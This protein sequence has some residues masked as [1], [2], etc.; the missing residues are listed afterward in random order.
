MTPSITRRRFLHASAAGAAMLS[1]GSCATAAS[2]TASSSPRPNG[3]TW[4]RGDFADRFDPWIEIDRSAYRNNV[5]E[6]S[7][8]AG[9][10]PILAVVK[11]NAYGLG[12]EA[13]GPLV[14]EMPEVG[15]IACVRV[16][17][18]LAMRDVGVTKPI[19]VMAEA[20]EDEMV[21]LVRHR[22]L[23]S[24]WL[25]DAPERIARVAARVGHPVP[26]QL[27]V[28]TGM[29][30]EGMPWDRARPWM[31]ELARSEVVEIDGTYTMF[32]HDLDHDREQLAR[33]EE[34][35]SWARGRSMPLGTLHASP[36]V[37][38]F[39]L[40]EAH[41]DM[42]RPGNALFGNYPRGEGVREM[43]R[44]QPVFRLR[45]RVVRVEYLDAGES[46]GFYS[47]FTAERPTWIGLL[48]AGR[49][50]GYPSS[51]NGRCEVLIGGRL[52][53]VVGG[54]NS[55][56]AII[57]IGATRTVEPGDVATLVGPDADAIHPHEVARRTEVSALALMQSMNPRLPRRII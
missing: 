29:N 17:E 56:H 51:A 45:A 52:Y 53:P 13:V 12:D 19:V 23:P 9:G 25:D 36:T 28:D 11:N 49:T 57:D 10:R 31:E 26:V 27:F 48:P 18:A 43:A 34:L 4:G 5:Q 47:T 39:H 55:A 14:A 3:V 1:A 24:V 54:V 8:L 21:T 15:G 35:L 46:A 40:P 44:L 33:F 16:E 20:S 41:Y 30:R 50:D 6:A 22:V 37:E 7:R 38:L 32:N 2:P 42:V